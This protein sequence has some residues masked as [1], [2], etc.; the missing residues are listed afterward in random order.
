MLADLRDAQSRGWV[1]QFLQEYRLNTQEG[2]ALLSLAE[3]FL[4]VPDPETADSL[5]ADKLGEGDWRSHKGKANSALVNTA[6]WGLVIGRALTS[7]SEHASA[8]RRLISR[9]G[10]PF[11]RQG[12]GAAMRMM[13]EIFVMGRNDR[14]SDRADAQ[15]RKCGLHRELRH[16]GRGGADLPRRGALL[17]ILR[18]RDPRGRQGGGRGPFDLGQVVGAPSALRGRAIWPL[19]PQPD[20][21]GR[22]AGDAGGGARHPLHHR[23]RGDRAAGDEPRHHR[24][25]GRPA[26]AEG[27]G[28]ARHGDPGLWQERPADR[29]L[30]RGARREDEAADRGAAGQGRLLGHRDQ[31]HPGA[32]PCRL[33]P[34]HP[35]G[36]DRRLLPRLRPRHAGREAHLSRLRHPQCADRRHPARMGRRQPRL[37]VPAAA[38]HGRR[39]LRGP[40]PRAGLSH[41]HLRAGRRPSRPARLPRPPPAR[42][43]RQFLASST[44]SPTRP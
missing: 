38:R 40:G 22:G 24:G 23:R 12:V 4:R 32:G 30:G 39:A 2:V 3:A 20:R 13:G 1:N 36:G 43:R 29:R 37:R 6:T 44:S 21:A 41:P 18:G 34:V 26:G 19:R 31:A 33:S 7:D 28:R 17:R 5:I 25:G 27:L 14:R 15:A 8:L 42:E 35:Q 9:T 16:A 11:V 10:E